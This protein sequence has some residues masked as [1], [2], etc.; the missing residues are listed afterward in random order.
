VYTPLGIDAQIAFAY[1]DG[2]I[3]YVRRDARA[4][5]AARLDLASSRIIGEPVVV[6]EQEGG[7]IDAARLASNGTLLYSRR[8]LP[9]NAPVLVDSTGTATALVAGLSGAFMNP[10]VSPDGRRVAVQ[11]ASAEGTDAWVYDIADGAQARVTRSGSVLGPAWEPDGRHL[12]YAS[13]VEG[14][15]ALWR[16]PA[17]G[18]GRPERLAAA[19]GLF[20]ASPTREPNLLLF[21]R[22]VN[23]VWSIWRAPMPGELEPQS[24]VT[25]TYDAFMPSLSPDGRWLIYAGSESG[26][27][28][29]YLRHFPGPG[30]A[31][32]VSLDGGTE[33][34]W[35]ADGRRIYYRGDRK[36]MYA[37]VTGGASPSITR[38]RMLFAD[39]FDG[40]M[41][42]PHRNYDVMPDGRRF[43][44]IAPTGDATPETIVVLNWT[45]ELRARLS[46]NR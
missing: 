32:Q 34:A 3:L 15:D 14:R 28:E 19:K 37:E 17:D 44:M 35:A 26:R 10:R 25:G 22:R 9:Q 1:Q 29:V 2:W 11:R 27:Y 6:L 7:G 36:L 8:V 33:P 45:P 23:G 43:V 16:I 46:A 12:V 39:T 5:M 20:A 13:T 40:D 4:L 18:N 38:R 41:P 42:M 24:V 21:Q 30:P 31:I